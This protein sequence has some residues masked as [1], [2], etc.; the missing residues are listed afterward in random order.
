MQVTERNRNALRSQQLI[1]EAYYELVEERGEGRIT[2]TDI[3]HRADINRTTFYAHYYGLEE[4]EEVL[5]AN[6]LKGFATWLKGVEE[7]EGADAFL[8]NPLPSLTRLGEYIE[9]S[10]PLFGA[11]GKRHLRSNETFGMSVR[12]ALLEATGKLEGPRLLRFDFIAAALTNVY[13]TWLV[14]SYGNM[15]IAELN[16]ILASYIKLCA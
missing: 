7:G 6:L 16:E 11:M 15:S 10:R 2:V 4:L 9:E 5:V 3:C 8:A 14:G 13:F 12:A 1:R